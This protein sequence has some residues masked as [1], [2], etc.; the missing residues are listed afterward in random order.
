MDTIVNE[1]DF[2]SVIFIINRTN[3]LSNTIEFQ[4]NAFL[5][6][7]IDLRIKD[8]INNVIVIVIFKKNLV[9]TKHTTSSTKQNTCTYHA[10]FYKITLPT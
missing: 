7:C 5:K 6:Q 10:M 8:T 9:F 4:N 2:I 1:I 3:H